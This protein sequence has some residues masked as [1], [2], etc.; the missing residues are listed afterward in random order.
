[1]RD[2]AA[3]VVASDIGV[4][5]GIITALRSTAFR[6]MQGE[7]SIPLDLTNKYSISMETIYNAANLHNDDVSNKEESLE[8]QAALCNAVKEMSQMARFHLHRARGN[9]SAVPKSARS[10]LLPAVCG[11][12]YLDSLAEFDHDVFHPTMVDRRR[13][14]LMLLLGRG[15]LT[16]SF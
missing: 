14:N 2:E 16:G 8:A 5:L 3:D 13:L 9:Q 15:W 10:C 7:S 12:Q 11:L 1:M 6:A 4:G